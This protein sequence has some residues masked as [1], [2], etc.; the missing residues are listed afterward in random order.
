M[1]KEKIYW[2]AA[3]NKRVAGW[4]QIRARFSG[5]DDK[6]LLYFTNNCKNLIRTLPIMQYDNSKPEDL[7]VRRTEPYWQ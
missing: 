5:Q 4:Q 7:K 3:D 2:Q 6:P 1:A